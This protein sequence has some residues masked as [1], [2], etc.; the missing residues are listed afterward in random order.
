MLRDATSDVIRLLVEKNYVLF[1]QKTQLGHKIDY[2]ELE[3]EPAFAGIGK[4]DMRF[5]WAM[6]CASSP[7]LVIEEEDVRLT[8][9]VHFAYKDRD[10]KAKLSEFRQRLPEN[11]ARGLKRMEKYSLQARVV[12]YLVLQQARDNVTSIISQDITKATADEKK[13]YLDQVK[14]AQQILM[15]QRQ[16][17][18][19]LDLGISEEGDTMYKESVDILALY[20]QQ[21]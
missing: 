20:M 6:G 2:P 21:H 15:E 16:R 12:E 7:F 1:A 13:A 9:C 5:L 14:V 8:A 10:R 18:E 11:L 17:I 19:G 3:K 4:F